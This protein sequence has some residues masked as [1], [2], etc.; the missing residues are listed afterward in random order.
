MS[1]LVSPI[2][3]WTRHARKPT[4]VLSTECW[5]YSGEFQRKDGAVHAGYIF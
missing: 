4:W 3:P 2:L 1:T 5:I